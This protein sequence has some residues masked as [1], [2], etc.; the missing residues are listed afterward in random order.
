MEVVVVLGAERGAHA[1]HDF[2]T[3]HY[4][5]QQVETTGFDTLGDGERRGDYNR[6]GVGHR[7]PLDVV[8]LNDVR[9][10]TVNQRRDLRRSALGKTEHRCLT[11]WLQAGIV[12][13]DLAGV[14][15]KPSQRRAQ[16]VQHQQACGVDVGGGEAGLPP[17]ELPVRQALGEAGLK[18]G[19]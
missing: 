10:G 3:G 9:Q 12:D 1:H 4:S 5:G 13:K 15:A 18:H 6:R 19:S 17:P 16:P 7:L 11:D 8:H 2:I 14:G